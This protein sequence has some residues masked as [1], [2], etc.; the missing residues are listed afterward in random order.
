MKLA[1]YTNS[2]GHKLNLVAML[3]M[4]YSYVNKN[5]IEDMLSFRKNH[6]G[7]VEVY[8]VTKK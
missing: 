4:V 3:P 6:I 1:R 8:G 2:A 5:S 7:E